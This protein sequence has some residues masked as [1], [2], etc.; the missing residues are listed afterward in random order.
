MKSKLYIAGLV[1]ISLLTYSCSND[2]VYEI[3]EVKNNNFQITSQAILKNGLNEKTIDS[4]TVIFSVLTPIKQ[5]YYSKF[6]FLITLL[7]F[8]SLLSVYQ[9]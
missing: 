1:S 7:I 4:T 2:D 5:E 9:S 3:P 6:R 8:S